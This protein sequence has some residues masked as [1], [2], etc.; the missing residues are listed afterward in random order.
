MAFS[1]VP[2]PSLDLGTGIGQ[3]QEPVRVQTF[4][5]GAAIE[6]FTVAILRGAAG[7]DVESPRIDPAEPVLRGRGNELRAVVEAAM[8]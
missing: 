6:R 8:G 1:V 3:R 5:A 2:S 7:R 4:I